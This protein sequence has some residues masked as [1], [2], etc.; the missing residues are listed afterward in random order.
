MKLSRS[1]KKSGSGGGREIWKV[2]VDN[3]MLNFF[4]E[5]KIPNSRNLSHIFTFFLADFQG[6]GFTMKSFKSISHLLVLL[7][8]VVFP[9]LVP[10]PVPRCSPFI[11][12]NKLAEFSNI[13]SDS[14]PYFP[15]PPCKYETLKS[16]ENVLKV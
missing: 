3:K 8:L 11:I 9:K 4:A 13:L 2:D 10:A 12:I 1:L 15:L 7:I 6:I 5:Y 16:Y 14:N